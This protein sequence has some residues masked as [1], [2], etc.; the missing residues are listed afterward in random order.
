LVNGLTKAQVWFLGWLRDGTRSQELLAAIDCFEEQT[1][2]RNEDASPPVCPM[3]LTKLRAKM[4]TGIRDPNRETVVRSFV[5]A[6]AGV[7]GDKDWG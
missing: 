4:G 1:R 7:L 5:L 2:R 3:V 6:A